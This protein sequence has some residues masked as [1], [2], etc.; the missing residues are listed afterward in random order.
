MLGV[1]EYETENLKMPA[2]ETLPEEATR[3]LA[4]NK[5]LLTPHI[6]GLTVE[7]YEKLSRYLAEK[8]IERFPLA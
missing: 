8:I 6:A 4:H 7:S 1:L 5:V 3:L 2:L